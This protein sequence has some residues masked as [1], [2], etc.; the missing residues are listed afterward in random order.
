M[1]TEM[2]A[3]CQQRVDSE[4][5]DVPAHYGRCKNSMCACGTHVHMHVCACVCVP[6]RIKDR[7]TAGRFASDHVQAFDDNLIIA[8]LASTCTCTDA[9]H[10]S[11]NDTTRH[12]YSFYSHVYAWA[13][14]RRTWIQQVGKVRKPLALHPWWLCKFVSVLYFTAVPSRGEVCSVLI[15]DIA[16][17]VVRSGSMCVA[18]DCILHFVARHL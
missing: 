8:K 9:V 2:L 4:G 13:V 5:W 6:R 11:I 7:D 15:Y 3:V 10:E 17:S 1:H 12:R 18:T 14:I 16:Q